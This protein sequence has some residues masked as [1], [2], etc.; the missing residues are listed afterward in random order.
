MSVKYAAQRFKDFS[1]NALEEEYIENKDC[2][3]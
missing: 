2:D 1:L 3:L